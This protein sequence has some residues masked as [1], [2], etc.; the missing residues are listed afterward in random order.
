MLYRFWNNL[1]RIF[2]VVAKRHKSS[3]SP[4]IPLIISSDCIVNSFGGSESWFIA[5][6][7]TY[8]IAVAAAPRV[9]S[10][11][12]VGKCNW[13]SCTHTHTQTNTRT[14]GHCSTRCELGRLLSQCTLSLDFNQCLLYVYI[15][16]YIYTRMY[17]CVFTLCCTL[18]AT[19]L[20]FWLLRLWLLLLGLTVRASSNNKMNGFLWLVYVLYQKE[21][22]ERQVASSAAAL[23]AALLTDLCFVLASLSSAIESFA[24][25]CCC[26]IQS[27][28]MQHSEPWKILSDSLEYEIDRYLRTF[29]TF[30]MISYL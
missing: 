23:L 29:K 6:T 24:F 5:A 30:I 21:L 1:K 27:F 20:D 7:L 16:I 18:N 11:K 12:Y 26:H 19:A 9:V 13:F 2:F 8:C 4:T 3:T 17:L 22:V 15:K 10:K 14:L 25:V 28:I